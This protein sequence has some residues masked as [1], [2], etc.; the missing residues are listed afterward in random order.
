MQRLLGAVLQQTMRAAQAQPEEHTGKWTFVDMLES[1]ACNDDDTE[2]WCTDTVDSTLPTEQTFPAAGEHALTLAIRQAAL[3][4]PIVVGV[5]PQS[6]DLDDCCGNYLG[7]AAIEGSV[8]LVFSEGKS[9]F[10]ANNEFFGNSSTTVHAGSVVTLTVAHGRL[11]AAVD[12][13]AL[14]PV[15]GRLAPEGRYRFAVSLCGVGQRVAITQSS[16]SGP[17]APTAPLGR[18]PVPDGEGLVGCRVTVKPQDEVAPAIA[19]SSLA[20]G[21][22]IP[23]GTILVAEASCERFGGMT[24]KVLEF[25]TSENAFQVDFGDQTDWFPACCLTPAATDSNSTPCPGD[26]CSSPSTCQAAIA[27]CAP[28]PG[29]ASTD[30]GQAGTTCAPTA[31]PPRGLDS[32]TPRLT[33]SPTADLLRLLERFHMA[34]Y[35]ELLVDAGYNSLEALQFA[36]AE[37]LQSLGMRRPHALLL[38]KHLPHDDG[39]EV[40]GS[41]CDVAENGERPRKRPRTIAATA[42]GS[43]RVTDD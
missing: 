19:T 33:F 6:T 7:E 26:T 24:G 27:A 38:M 32:G 42:A 40:A 13:Q 10:M 36:T 15:E 1:V 16:G 18:S 41:S 2:A 37:D 25:N 34:P 4:R 39:G 11:L 20:A 28:S 9:L 29:R 5:L 43:P 21:R 22:A 35:A 30:A 12:G 17:P 3:R 8:G 31:C 23:W 14:P